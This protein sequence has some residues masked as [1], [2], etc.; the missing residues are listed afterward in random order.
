MA[1]AVI[2]PSSF[3]SS[4]TPAPSALDA[5]ENLTL[6]SDRELQFRTSNV[7]RNHSEA[8]SKMA[9]SSK[10]ELIQ[11]IPHFKQ[12]LAFLIASDIPQVRSIAMQ[13]DEK[14]LRVFIVVDE[15]DFD[16]NERIYDKEEHIIDVFNQM[17]FDFHITCHPS[18]S[19]PRLEKVL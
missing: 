7:P 6:R 16:V 4:N 1:C 13:E 5:R 10:N 15:Y 17:D 8:P 12:F 19:D 11:L 9:V 2:R 3:G 14:L 18:M